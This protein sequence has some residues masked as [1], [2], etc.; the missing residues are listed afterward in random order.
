MLHVSMVKEQ[1]KSSGK[2]VTE[3][4]EVQADHVWL[5]MSLGASRALQE[6]TACLH[7]TSKT[8]TSSHYWVTELNV[9]LVGPR[10]ATDILNTKKAHRINS[11]RINSAELIEVSKTGLDWHFLFKPTLCSNSDK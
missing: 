1:D 7:I 10:V 5:S 8:S 2:R 9:A 4:Y 3:S 11:D 6:A